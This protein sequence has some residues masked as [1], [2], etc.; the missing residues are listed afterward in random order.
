M[1]ISYLIP[2]EIEHLFSNKAQCLV[3]RKS[4]HWM[5]QLL[6]NM[7]SLRS[8]PHWSLE[9]SPPLS[10]PPFFTL[11]TIV[12]FTHFS[13]AY[14]F[15]FLHMFKAQWWW[16]TMTRFYPPLSWCHIHQAMW[17][18]VDSTMVLTTTTTHSTALGATLP[19]AP[20]F[21]RPAKVSAHICLRW[22]YIM[23][24]L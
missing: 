8:F 21:L 22:M 13:A 24:D 12:Q 18:S 3:Y 16:F 20:H 7:R 10:P 4:R 15:Y 5:K 1:F 19:N 9:H 11:L 6:C 23:L 17:I 2:Q 14:H